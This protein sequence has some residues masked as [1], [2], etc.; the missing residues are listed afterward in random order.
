[1]EPNSLQIKFDGQSHQIDANTLINTLIHYNAIINEINTQYGGGS[2][3]INIKV[4]AIKEGSFIIDL[5]LVG[6]LGLF[7]PASMSYLSDLI[8]IAEGVFGAYKILRGKPACSE[9]D[10]S[11]IKIDN[12]S[13]NNCVINVYNAPVVREAISKS[14]V[15][16]N[17]DSNV[18]GIQFISD[19]STVSYEKDNFKDLI[20]DDFD[21][22]EVLP[23]EKYVDEEAT[24]VIIK[25]S[26]EAG[27][28]WSFYYRGNKIQI[29]IKDGI[30]MDLIANG[31]RFGKGDTLK[32]LLRTIQ[33]FNPEYGVYEN[34]LYKILAFYEHIDASRQPRL[35]LE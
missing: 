13:L 23:G 2:K 35:P 18:E 31:E 14:I 30:L 15:T 16:A 4:N 5:S 22:E 11:A 26:F 17:D 29:T 32:V 12:V 10:K 7:S 28:K 33:R 27:G 19:K 8:A 6:F 3:N 25:L 20:Y 21:K 34:K 9:E 1:M 24:L